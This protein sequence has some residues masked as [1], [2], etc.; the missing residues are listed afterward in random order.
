MGTESR[1]AELCAAAEYVKYMDDLQNSKHVPLEQP[2]TYSGLPQPYYPAANI[3]YVPV[4]ISDAARYSGVFVPQYM[5]P[6]VLNPYSTLSQVSP[7]IPPNKLTLAPLPSPAPSLSSP[8]SALGSTLSSAV[9]TPTDERAL[10]LP[11]VEPTSSIAKIISSPMQPT[12]KIPNLECAQKNDHQRT[13]TL[14]KM[15]P[16]KSSDDAAAKVDR[17]FRQS[18]GPQTTVKRQVEK[19]KRPHTVYVDQNVAQSLDVHFR[20]SL[21]EMAWK[22]CLAKRAK[23]ATPRQQNN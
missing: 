16:K 22:E 9:S 2:V 4:G 21:G 11:R 10:I 5:S 12:H 13:I 18:L 23:L 8:G 3:I 14:V 15:R 7:P 17:H 20:K 6:S 19:T 1:L